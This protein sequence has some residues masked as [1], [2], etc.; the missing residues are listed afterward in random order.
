[1]N[2]YQVRI[3]VNKMDNEKY[4]EDIVESD[5]YKLLLDRSGS[6]KSNVFKAFPT[7]KVITPSKDDYDKG[8]MTRYFVAKSNDMH[9]QIFEVDAS[10]YKQFQKNPF[11]V[12]A[13]MR[14][15]IT[16]PVRSVY[17]RGILKNRGVTDFNM[18]SYE[19]IQLTM[20][21]IDTKISSLLQFYKSD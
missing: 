16:G 6:L 10:G 18:V 17:D 12:V 4:G 15:K 19:Q 14:W 3:Q 7:D 1:M 21:K 11:Y 9:S 2:I 20:P 13:Q 5:A 8:M